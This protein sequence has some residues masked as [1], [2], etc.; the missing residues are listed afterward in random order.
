MEKPI[1]NNELRPLHLG[2]LLDRAFRLYRRHFRVFVGIMIFPVGI[3]TLTNLLTLTVRSNWL[4][5]DSDTALSAGFHYWF[6]GAYVMYCLVY[7]IALA[8]GTHAVAEAYLGRSPTVRGAY[9]SV[10]AKFWRVIDLFFSVVLRVLAAYPG[11][12]FLLVFVGLPVT[13]AT[14]NLIHPAPSITARNIIYLIL[15]VYFGGSMALSVYLAVRYSLSIPALVFENLGVQASIHRSV[16][17]TARRRWQVLLSTI[18]ALVVARIGVDLFELPFRVAIL[19]TAGGGD[20]QRLLNFALVV[21]GGIGQ[22]MTGSLV[23]IVLALCYYDARIRKEAFD[24]QLM[25]ASLERPSPTTLV[26]SPSLDS[27]DPQA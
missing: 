9:A 17:L 16:Y 23:V 8:A 24:L 5:S 18:C 15:G 4:G 7:S 22:A 27:L 14:S 11:A 21:S 25:L 26:N 12:V 2:E 10:R 19:L 20:W 6:W 3:A 1:V 13:A